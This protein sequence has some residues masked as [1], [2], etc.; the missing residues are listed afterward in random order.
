MRTAWR[1][2]YTAVVAP[3]PRASD[4]IAV[5]VNAGVFASRRKV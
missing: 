1:T 2:L 3:I 4:R 5:R